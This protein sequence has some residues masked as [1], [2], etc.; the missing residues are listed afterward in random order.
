[1]PEPLLPLPLLLEDPAAFTF[2]D[3]P[4]PIEEDELLVALFA[5]LAALFAELAALLA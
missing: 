4:R 1:M 3:N 5:E 2:V